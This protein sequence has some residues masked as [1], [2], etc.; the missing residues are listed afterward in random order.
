MLFHTWTFLI[1]MMVVL[2]VLFALGRTRLWIPWLLIASYAFYGWWNPYYLILVVYSTLLDFI[3]VA[4]M[5]HCPK[6]RKKFDGR[7]RLAGLRSGDPVLKA[8]FVITSAGVVASLGMAPGGTCHAAAHHGCIRPCW[9]CSWPLG[10]LLAA[11]ASGCS[12]ASSTT[13]RSCSSSNTRASWSR[14]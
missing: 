4:L 13:S 12:S 1:F 9:C 11:A 7:A 5:D 2:P 10:A 8:A 3:L 6:E 14:I